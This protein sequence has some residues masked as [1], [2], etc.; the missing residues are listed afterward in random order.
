MYLQSVCEISIWF[1]K[2]IFTDIGLQSIFQICI[3]KMI[4]PRRM[5][6]TGHVAQMGDKRMHVGY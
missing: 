1:C 4:K 5:R 2:V 3:I 6:W